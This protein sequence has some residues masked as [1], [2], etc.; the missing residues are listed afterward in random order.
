MRDLLLKIKEEYNSKLLDEVIDIV[1]DEAE[2]N[3]ESVKEYLEDVLA[4]GC[5]SG[6]VR[7]L[8]Y[9]KDTRAFFARHFEEI[10]DIINDNDIKV[11]ELNANELAWLGFEYMA[12]EIY[13]ILV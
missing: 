12:Q 7:R 11:E 10:F 5:Q 1:L 6:F 2:D 9:Y 3:D 4:Y 8:I 13:A